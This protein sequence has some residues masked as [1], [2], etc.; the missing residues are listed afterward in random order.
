MP[1]ETAS[2]RLIMDGK[3]SDV[4]KDGVTPAEAVILAM[5]HIGEVG[6]YPIHDI[7]PTGPATDDV[8]DGEETKHAVRTVLSEV[9]RLRTKYGKARVNKL[10][11]GAI[12]SLPTSFE[13]AEEI[14]TEQASGDKDEAAED[15]KTTLFGSKEDAIQA[16]KAA[17]EDN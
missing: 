7:V 2:I 9:R 1:I 8:Q 3:G 12:P 15:E 14:V 5:D 17:Q 16:A 11:P 13:E 4:P 6:K 10:F